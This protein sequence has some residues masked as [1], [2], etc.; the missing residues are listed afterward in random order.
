[1]NFPPV[2]EQLDLIQLHAVDVLPIEELEQKLQRSYNKKQPLIIKLGCDPSRPDLHLGHAVVLSKLRQFQD[3]GHTATLIIGDFTGIIGD[4]TGKSKT[5]PVLT[6][7]ESKENGRSY[8]EQAS[9]ILDPNSVNILYNSDWLSNLHFEDVIRLSSKYTVA[10]MLERDD[11]SKRYKTGEPISLHEFLYPL[12]QAM[13]SVHI[14][15]DVEIGGTDQKFNLLVGREVQ[16][17]YGLEPQCILT[18]PILEGTDG[19]EKMSKSLDNYIGLSDTPREMFGKTMS[20]PDVLIGRYY[21]LALFSPQSEVETIE[22]QLKNGE[23][24]P[25]NCKVELAKRIVSRYHS[26]EAGEEAFAEFERIFVKKDIPD[27][28]DLLILSGEN[29]TSELP[30]VDLLVLTSLAESKSDA[31]RLI[32]QGGVSVDGEKVTDPAMLTDITNER[33]LKVGKRKFLKVQYES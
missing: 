21:S 20:I 7:E 18:L 12:A 1:M 6:L 14:N 25:R 15:S 30:I 22:Q 9:K 19:V 5:R 13:D 29:A 11:F 33:L 27:V 31:R 4:P 26:A 28:I 3:L 17:A 24:H 23:L 16:R 2:K 10:Q 8:F 32:Q